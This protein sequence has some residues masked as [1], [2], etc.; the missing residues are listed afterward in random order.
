ML[1]AKDH[2]KRLVDH[3]ERHEFFRRFDMAAHTDFCDVLAQHPRT[4]KVGCGAAM[5]FKVPNPK[6]G[7]PLVWFRRFDQSED[8]LDYKRVVQHIHRTER[9][10]WLDYSPIYTAFRQAVEPHI[11][12]F[13]LASR[14]IAFASG[15]AGLFRC[16]TTGQWLDE[17]D[18]QVDHS[19]PTTFSILLAAFAS[20]HNL[21]FLNIETES[22]FPIPGRRL[23]SFALCEKW[24][25]FHRQHAR[26]RMLSV[27]A[28][29]DAPKA[30]GLI[31]LLEK[32]IPLPFVVQSQTYHSIGVT[33]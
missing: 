33:I 23:A 12:E 24:I 4:E 7:R 6:T 26:L 25:A 21:D 18:C 2:T 9:N 11:D 16:D 29:L 15:M 10:R 31:D 8:D 5:F 1:T 30:L 14:V 17:R 3:V 13:R 20:Y 32:R 22:S 19:Y 27:K 28:N